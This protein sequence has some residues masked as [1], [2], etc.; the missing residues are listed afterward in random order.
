MVEGRNSAAFVVAGRGRVLVLLYAPEDED[1]EE[2][3]R[4]DVC[5]VGRVGVSCWEKRRRGEVRRVKAFNIYDALYMCEMRGVYW[6]CYM[7]LVH[8]GLTGLDWTGRGRRLEGR[9]RVMIGL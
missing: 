7:R 3:L 5:G 9:G 8:W 2:L 4:D 1:E 6:L